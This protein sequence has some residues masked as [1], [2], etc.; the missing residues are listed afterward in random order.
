MK[1]KLIITGKLY[2][3][4]VKDIPIEINKQTTEIRINL[5]FQALIS[6]LHKFDKKIPATNPNSNNP[7]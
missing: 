4:L 2:S 3:K 6:S 5:F 7:K 1:N